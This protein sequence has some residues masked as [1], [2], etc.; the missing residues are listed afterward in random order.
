MSKKFNKIFILAMIFTLLLLI[1]TSFASDIDSDLAIASNDLSVGNDN[2]LSV[3]DNADLMVNDDDSAIDSNL[4]SDDSAMGSNLI[5][6]EDLSIDS[7]IVESDSSIKSNHL[8]D[9]NTL[10]YYFDSK[11][12][13][14]NGDG[15]FE[16]PYK[17]LT[18][19]R[20]MDNS[21]IHLSNG[22]YN[23]TPSKTHTGVTICGQDSSS[24]IIN[25]NY[26]NYRVND[27]SILQNLTLINMRLYLEGSLN[28]SNINFN[29]SVRYGSYDNQKGGSIFP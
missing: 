2:L 11:V 12:A 28:A 13:N 8:S 10:E 18:E 15:S 20:I 25:G 4:V 21:I 14:D 26:G 17:Y 5:P 7:E 1:P 24:T 23:F 22:I 6:N 27:F 3:E 9:G 19:D 16:N 29:G